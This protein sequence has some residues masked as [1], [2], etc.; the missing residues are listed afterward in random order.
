MG[1]LMYASL[2]KVVVLFIRIIFFKNKKYIKE[3][4]VNR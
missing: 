4:G 2:G 1:N 3:G